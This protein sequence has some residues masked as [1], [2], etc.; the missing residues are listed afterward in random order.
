MIIRF[1]QDGTWEADPAEPHRL[2]IEALNVM[3]ANA[4]FERVL[5]RMDTYLWNVRVMQ[6]RVGQTSGR[7]D[8]QYGVYHL[9][10]RQP[11]VDM[12]LMGPHSDAPWSITLASARLLL[13]TFDPKAPSL[14]GDTEELDPLPGPILGTPITPSTKGKMCGACKQQ[15]S[16]SPSG[17]FCGNEKCREFKDSPA[18]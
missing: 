6:V 15:L 8:R 5:D 17:H 2:L 12:V 11:N 14:E 10:V 1:Y 13:P 3:G 16:W 4:T 7:N 9:R 18:F